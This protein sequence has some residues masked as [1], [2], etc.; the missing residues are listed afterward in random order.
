MQKRMSAGFTLPELM[1]VV[2]VIAILA[3]MA[4]PSFKDTFQAQR[5]EGATE[6]LLAA[7][8]NAKAEAIKT[9]STMRIVFKPDTVGVSHSTWCYGMT[10]AGDA[11]CVCTADA[12]ATND[13]ATGSVV[14]STDYAGVKL[15]Y[16]TDAFRTFNPLRGTSNGGTVTF[17]GGNNKMLGVSI[18]TIGK[19]R[20]CLPS[21][22]TIGS[23]RD[24]GACS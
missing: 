9:N 18:L 12:D 10:K 6:A 22:S 24:N 4:A 7:L 14:Q 23:Y 15:R 5:V 11:T 2:A 1:I 17:D 20:V 8:Q 13:C 16:N 19:I 3:A 21:G